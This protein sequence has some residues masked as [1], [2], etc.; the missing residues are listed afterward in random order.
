[1]MYISQLVLNSRNRIARAD[2]SDRY[3]LHRTLL[4]AFPQNMSADER[5]LFRVDDVDAGLPIPILIQSQYRPEWDAVERLHVRD[6]LV[7]IPRVRE[8]LPRFVEKQQL[9]FRLQ[10][11]PTVKRDGK[12]HAIY[13]DD[14]LRDWLARKSTQHGFAVYTESVQMRKLGNRYGKG[15][16]Q[17]WHAVQFDG[18][19]TV[20]DIDNFGDSLARGIGSAKAFG[21]GLLS[22]PYRAV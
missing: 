20:Q 18:V 13:P 14:D 4:N 2:L 21:F 3:E 12:R 9:A 17:I 16:R 15:R 11:N 1:M 8:V 6:Y 22:V 19:L 7:Q 10:A 5:V